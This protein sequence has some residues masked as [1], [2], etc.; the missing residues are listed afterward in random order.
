VI[1]V[2]TLLVAMAPNNS[3]NNDELRRRESAKAQE[4]NNNTDTSQNDTNAGEE[5]GEA[6]QKRLPYPKSIGFIVGNEFCERFSFYGM[7]AILSI[8]FKSKLHYSEDSATVIY[9]AFTMLCYFTPIFGAMLADQFFGKFRT[10]F[11]ISLIYVLGHA[12][13]TLAAVPTLGLPPAEFSL[14]GLALIAI[15]TGGIK[16]CVSAFGG[17]Q[18]KLPEQER[19]LQ[20]FFSVFYF[21]I[22]AGSLISTA[23]TPILREDVPCFG[24]DTCYSL[25]FGVPAI[26]MLVATIFF[27]IGKPFYVMKAPEGSITTKVIGSISHATV[28]KFTSSEKKEHWMDHAED[29]YDK[30]L[31]ADV[32]T[33]L[34]VLVIFIPIPAFWALF[35]QTG[36]RWTFQAQRLNG[37][38]G[39]TIIKPDQ[40]QIVNPLLILALI[41]LFD[42][43]IYPMFAKINFLKKPLQRIA[44]GGI[45][46]ACSFFVS[47]FLELKIEKTYEVVPKLGESHLHIMNTINCPIVVKMSQ[48]AELLH[49]HDIEMSLNSII[50]DLKPELYSVEVKQSSQLPE[51][52]GLQKASFEFNGNDKEVTAYLIRRNFQDNDLI[53][54][55]KIEKAG[56]PKKQEDAS[57]KL[58]FIFNTGSET[59]ETVVL[60]GSEEVQLQSNESYNGLAETP[61]KKVAPG[62]YDILVDDIKIDEVFFL[63]GGVHNMVINKNKT[64]GTMKL[65]DFLLTQDNSIHMLWLLPQ[66]FVI[67][68]G[69]IML[70][71][72]GLEFSYSQAPESMKSV[73]QAAW[74]LNVAFGNLIVILIAE[75]KAFDS[76]ASEFFMFGIF[77]LLDMVLFSFLAYRYK[78]VKDIKKEDEDIQLEETEQRQ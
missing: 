6:G 72:T 39:S 20:T 67:T 9:H 41:P 58:R 69:E 49:S 24:E 18:F 25:A 46:T 75:A 13:K 68:V 19:Q 77:M 71:I 22:N 10:I 52:R 38:I 2:I 32:K 65:N 64:D 44:V 15:G 29:K 12:L 60:R 43:L 33:L 54:A 4:A 1:S 59:L 34:R 40:M 28:K 53:E 48:N 31:I 63:P 27:V 8:Y 76:Q 7:K 30:T 51:C 11:W 16:P 50:Y 66:Y 78:Y 45:L 37:M 56:E 21:A 23:L 42:Q 57:A 17:D 74:L 55:I 61:Y 62:S 36:S 26:L 5:G 73:L 35:D 14:L 3:D 70:S 47:G